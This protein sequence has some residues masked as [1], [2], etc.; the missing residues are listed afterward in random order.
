MTSANENSLPSRAIHSQ[1][2]STASDRE[3][4]HIISPQDKEE[5]KDVVNS[6]LKS[7]RMERN[8]RNVMSRTGPQN[9]PRSGILQDSTGS[10]TTYS[11]SSSRM[12]NNTGMSGSQTHRD[13]TYHRTPKQPGVTAIG[14]RTIK[15]SL[16]TLDEDIDKQAALPVS[17]EQMHHEKFARQLRNEN[18]PTYSPSSSLKFEKDEDTASSQVHS[19]DINSAEFSG[20]SHNVQ[21]P[22]RL[23]NRKDNRV[24]KEHSVETE[25]IHRHQIKR[26]PYTKSTQLQTNEKTVTNSSHGLCDNSSPSNNL[27]KQNQEHP[28]DNDYQEKS[29]NPRETSLSPTRSTPTSSIYKPR[30]MTSSVHSNCKSTNEKT[31]TKSSLGLKEHSMK[32][33]P[34]RPKFFS[35]LP[36]KCNGMRPKSAALNRTT[37]SSS[38]SSISQSTSNVQADFRSIKLR[39]AAAEKTGDRNDSPR[40]EGRDSLKNSKYMSKSSDNIFSDVKLKPVIKASQPQGCKSATLSKAT[41]GRLRLQSKS[42]DLG[43]IGVD[44]TAITPPNLVSSTSSLSMNSSCYKDVD[45]ERDSG[46]QLSPWRERKENSTNRDKSKKEIETEYKDK[47]TTGYEKDSFECV[48]NITTFYENSSRS[49]NNTG[50]PS[51]KKSENISNLKEP[52]KKSD[53]HLETSTSGR[54]SL[55]EK[56]RHWK[57]SPDISINTTSS[58]STKAHTAVYKDITTS[59]EGSSHLDRVPEWIKQKALNKRN[60]LN[61]E[62][63]RLSSSLKFQLEKKT[64]IEDDVSISSKDESQSQCSLNLTCSSIDSSLIY[65]NESSHEPSYPVSRF[66]VENKSGENLSSSMYISK[67]PND[68]VPNTA[69]KSTEKNESRNE[70]PNAST[71]RTN[72][73]KSIADRFCRTKHTVSTNPVSKVNKIDPIVTS[74]DSS[75]MNRKPMKNI[76]E[77]IKQKADGIKADK[78]E[79]KPEWARGRSPREIKLGNLGV[80]AETG[81]F[82]YVCT[83]NSKFSDKANTNASDVSMW[84]STSHI[85]T[86]KSDNNKIVRDDIKSIWASRGISSTRDNKTTQFHKNRNTESHLEFSKH[87][88]KGDPNPIESQLKSPIHHNPSVSSM[89]S[90]STCIASP[91]PTKS[92][93]DKIS[94]MH[95]SQRVAGQTAA[96]LSESP[97]IVSSHSSSTSVSAQQENDLS[98]LNKTTSYGTASSNL[99]YP[100]QSQSQRSVKEETVS[101]YPSNNNHPATPQMRNIAARPPWMKSKSLRHIPFYPIQ[102]NELSP[103]YE[104]FRATLDDSSSTISTTSISSLASDA[105]NITTDSG[106]GKSVGLPETIAMSSDSFDEKMQASISKENPYTA[107]ALNTKN[108]ME[109]NDKPGSRIET[110]KKPDMIAFEKTMNYTSNRRQRQEVSL[111]Q[112]NLM[113][114]ASSSRPVISNSQ[115]SAILS[116]TRSNATTPKGVG[117]EIPD[118]IPGTQTKDHRNSKDKDKPKESYQEYRYN[119]LKDKSDDK[120]DIAISQHEKDHQ[121]DTP[122]KGARSE[123]LKNRLLKAKSLQNIETTN[124]SPSS[125]LSKYTTREIAKRPSDLDLSAHREPRIKSSDVSHHLSSKSQE[126]LDQPF[127]RNTSHRRSLEN[128]T[129][130]SRTSENRLSGGTKLQGSGSWARSERLRELTERNKDKTVETNQEC[131]DASSS[132]S[133][134][135]SSAYYENSK[136]KDSSLL[137]EK[138]EKVQLSVSSNKL[139]NIDDSNQSIVGEDASRETISDNHQ[140]V[141]RESF[142][143]FVTPLVDVNVF[144]GSK[145][146]LQCQVAGKPPPNVHW[147]HDRNPIEVREITTMH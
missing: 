44:S 83:G 86:P 92:D 47:N 113:M 32:A 84:K 3:K 100:S 66:N 39:S 117:G 57:T 65:E 114:S 103:R 112:S 105:S 133:V 79:E 101:S 34:A 40:H 55:M 37:E 51:E 119:Y 116:I 144:Y 53:S 128:K 10:A 62:N 69:D 97:L 5:N 132:D 36:S 8:F 143:S 99:K 124:N 61:L 122:P 111:K 129:V 26:S 110:L 58:S 76:E 52:S 46:Q 91:P 127:P 6:G 125:L 131:M 78:S 29:M 130:I 22:D 54:S 104:P 95:S 11:H 33:A 59:N 45:K 19:K 38:S 71:E 136:L 21:S 42:S 17:G 134:A 102:D 126:D 118:K 147:L 27:K 141:Q 75:W 98:S 2:F 31:M 88:S 68:L 89:S 14:L 85:Q 87:N 16:S 120:S 82:Q 48:N 109:H 106:Y 138:A 74:I 77:L 121:D 94:I 50:T 41:A 18:E 123:F 146:T 73:S 96:I 135:Q 28:S 67:K 35:N 60:S 107:K 90:S 12:I 137:R 93:C 24:N 9:K 1:D 23:G 15:K 145:A 56:I 63:S 43:R 115:D 80:K 7:L 25:I 70:I 140:E 20:N 108:S 81:K 72:V 13:F 139:G 4:V 64:N 30:I 142:P 49:I